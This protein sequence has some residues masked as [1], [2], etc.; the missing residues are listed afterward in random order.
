MSEKQQEII[1]WLCT[2]FEDKYQKG[3]ALIQKYHGNK[4]Y[5]NNFGNL[6]TDDKKRK[7]EYELSKL[8]GYTILEYQ[9]KKWLLDNPDL[10]SV[11]PLCPECGKPYTPQEGADPLCPV[12]LE[13]LKKK[14]ADLQLKNQD[15]PQIQNTNQN[16]SPETILNPEPIPSPTPVKDPETQQ[17]NQ[18]LSETTQTEETIKTEE[19]TPN[20]PLTPEILQAKI[21]EMEKLQKD[22]K[23]TPTTKQTARTKE[24]FKVAEEV[25]TMILDLQSQEQTPPIPKITPETQPLPI[26]P[27][28]EATSSPA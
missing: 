16:P 24:Y 20:Q 4:S 5:V 15:P 28:Q 23:I 8:A 22:L 14:E 7:I 27:A 21:F 18:T 10:P 19:T 9:Q 1:K 2:N 17:P 6:I 11:D 25:R 3:L 12:C 26:Q 13:I